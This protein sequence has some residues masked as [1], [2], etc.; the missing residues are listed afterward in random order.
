MEIRDIKA[1]LNITT[2]LHHYSLKSDKHDFILCPFHDDKEPSLKI[3]PLTNTFYCL[4]CG[5]NGDSIQFIEMY[6]K[7]TKHQAIEKAKTLVD[8]LY[9]INTKPMEQ[10]QEKETL[11]RLAVLCKVAQDNKASFKKVDKAQ[12]YFKSRGLSPEKRVKI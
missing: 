11:P 9:S 1:G 8:P 12:E 7:I 10:T 5:A 6:E 4:S 3:Y 2:V